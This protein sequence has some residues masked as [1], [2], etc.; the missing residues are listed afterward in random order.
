MD[1]LRIPNEE[2]RE[3]AK[4]LFSR[5]HEDG[6]DGVVLFGA[7]NVYYV[8]GMYHLPTERPCAVG[9]T[10]ERIDIVVPRLEREHAERS[11]FNIDDVHVYF[12]F[13]QGNPMTLVAEMCEN[14]GIAESSVAVDSDGSPRRN[15][16]TGPSLSSLIPGTVG[17]EDY[18][19]T[20]RERKSEAEID[21]I[22]EASTWAHL[23]H[24]L[25]QEKL[26]VGRRPISISAEVEVEGTDAIL[27]TLGERY[28]M[29]SWSRP[30]QC[31]FTTGSVTSLPH[32]VDQTTRIREGDNIV[33]I[34][35]PTIGG[36]TTELE[37]TLI[38]GEPSDEQRDYFEIMC[39]SQ[40]VAIDTIEPGIEYAA[41]EEA[42]MSYYKEQGVH[43]YV[44]HHIGHNIGME[45][46]ERP[47]LDRGYDGTISPGE[48][49]TVEPGFYVPEVG[50]FRHSDTILVTET[51]TD[52]LTYYPRDIDQLIV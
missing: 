20:M 2:Y 22:R 44:Q 34:V 10:D 33:T 45:G 46:H 14:L 27:D 26:A 3:R 43:E 36:Y 13:P 50:G 52:T 12:D 40:K 47:F 28:E 24:R 15:G 16:Y 25:L 18:V 29:T 7:L 11:D 4:T 30:M 42:V 39:E 35:K 48:L 51:G 19:T 23:G 38:V 21:L 49:Y 8:T 17:V 32:S 31:N 6:Y 5:A 1:R 37:R 41:V 9:L